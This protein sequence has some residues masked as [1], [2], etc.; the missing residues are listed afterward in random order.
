M[1]GQAV[2]RILLV[3]TL[4]V[5]AHAIKPF[6]LKNITTHLLYS[7]R[8]FAFALPDS[9]RPSFD[10]VSQLAVN[11]SN[12]LF[13]NG[14]VDR[15]LA[16][17]MQAYAGVVAINTQP[18]VVDSS[19]ESKPVLRPARLMIKRQAPVE[20]AIRIEQDEPAELISNTEEAEGSEA[21]VSG[22]DVASIKA[23]ETGETG[24]ADTSADSSPVILPA[25]QFLGAAIPVALP[26]INVV[27]ALSK[28]KPLKIEQLQN[29][30]RRIELLF[31][32][33][34]PKKPDCDSRDRK[35]TRLIALV[36]EAK[37]LRT[38]LSK[39][40][41]SIIPILECED[42]GT[43]AV[44]WDEEVAGPQ[45]EFS[46]SQA[47]EAPVFT[48]NPQQTSDSCTMQPEQ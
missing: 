1:T 43:E 23:G 48:T 13:E 47:D 18:T 31:H 44:T 29:L 5:T 30:P 4:I 36:E 17:Q 3:I 16:T 32:I 21:T 45:V 46:Q 2:A 12:S 41:R 42:E 20:R 10:Q 8:S 19:D 27:C 28:V 26:P 35:Q 14:Q 38:D 7:T 6:S 25:A 34:L 33:D 40:D 39:L 37:K 15:S 24:A 11:F 22:D 9:T